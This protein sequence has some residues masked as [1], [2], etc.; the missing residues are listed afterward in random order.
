[1]LL[2]RINLYPNAFISRVNSLNELPL[3]LNS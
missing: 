1:V 2:D 3:M